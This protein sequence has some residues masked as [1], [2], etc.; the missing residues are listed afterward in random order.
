MTIATLLFYEAIL[1]YDSV[2]R[3]KNHSIY[4]SM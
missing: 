4:G 3:Q 1:F 2:L